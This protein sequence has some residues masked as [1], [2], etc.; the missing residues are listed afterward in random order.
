LN[1]SFQT[2]RS[3]NIQ[4]ANAKPYR[5]KTLPKLFLTNIAFLS[6]AQEKVLAKSI[7]LTYLKW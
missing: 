6:K 1:L 4:G 7:L 3:W 5:L 2:A